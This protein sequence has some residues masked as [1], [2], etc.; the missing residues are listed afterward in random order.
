VNPL[1]SYIKA[2]LNVFLL[3]ELDNSRSFNLSHLKQLFNP[4]AV[5]GY[6]E[7]TLGGS[8]TEQ[9]KDRVVYRLADGKTLKVARSQNGLLINEAEIGFGTND[10]TAKMFPELIEYDREFN[11][12]LT[13]AVEPM[14]NE[15][16]KEVTGITWSGFLFVLGAAFPKILGNVTKGQMVQHHHA[17]DKHYANNFVR[18]VISTTKECKLEPGTLTKIETWGVANGR[19]VI[20]KPSIKGIA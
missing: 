10:K 18:Q 8:K 12:L 3:E 16:F 9:N 7:Q 14:T 4:Q 6:A 1:E 5:F 15:R 13:A 2:A 20:V 19:P 17:F 11:W